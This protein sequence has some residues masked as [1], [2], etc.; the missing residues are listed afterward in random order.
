M[1]QIDDV[2]QLRNFAVYKQFLHIEDRRSGNLVVLQPNDIQKDIRGHI[3]EKDK[4][5]EPCRIIILKARRTGCS[6]IIQGT[7]AHRTFTRRMFTGLTV[8]HDLDTA[9]Y[10][11]GMTERMY[12]NLPDA[13]RPAKRHKARG[14]FLT[15]ENDS[16]LRVETAEDREAGRGLASRFLHGS[17]VAFWPD[18]RRTLLA[19]RQAVPYE[20]GTCIAL[21]STANGV[22][23]AFHMEW[24]RAENGESGYIPLF[25][26]WFVFPDYKIV[27]LETTAL[28]LL[29]DDEVELRELGC[30]DG[31]LLWRRQ[32]I[33]NECGGD[34]DLFHQEYPSTAV[35]AFIVSGRPYFGSAVRHLQPVAPLRTGDFVGDIKKGSKVNFRD[36]PHGRLRLWELPHKDSR[37]VIFCDPAG[38]VTLDRVETFDDR[39]EGED[40]SCVQV[41]NCRT[42]AQVAEWHGRIDLSLLADVCYRIGTVYNRGVVAVEMNGGYG[43]AV[44][45]PLYNRLGYDNCYVRRQVH[46]IGDK[47]T[48]RLG[49]HTTSITRPQML[50]GLRDIVRDSPQ[51]I[52]SEGFKREASTFV[53]ARNGKPMG[54]SG[55]HDDRVMALAGCYELYKEYAQSTPVAN[56]KR[57]PP[58]S[59]AQGS[60]F[61]RAG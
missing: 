14:R 41:I 44:V 13:L 4:A 2:T 42:G 48:R 12:M 5:S 40:Y 57:K 33:K 56:R 61:T 37:Y 21:E 30:D 46:T 23:N 1:A 16:W 54:D 60:A 15:L 27:Y 20:P 32:T 43:A 47:P 28:E 11:F 58:T 24:V 50:E 38:S 8:A 26:P 36:E 19:L 6:T 25:Y 29:D 9:S 7:M 34:V 59:F 22:G 35:E 52:K 18:A 53:I 49:W 17:E 39:G 45:D 31:Q 51:L 55:C 10:L 3:I